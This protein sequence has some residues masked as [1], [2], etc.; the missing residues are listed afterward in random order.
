MKAVRELNIDP[1][2]E[3]EK[4]KFKDTFSVFKKRVAP[5]KRKN[6]KPP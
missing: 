1:Y 5:K 6:P 4:G 3:M 2:N